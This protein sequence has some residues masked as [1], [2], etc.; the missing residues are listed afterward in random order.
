[1]CSSDLIFDALRLLKLAGTTVIMITHSLAVLKQA[2][3]A[4]LLCNGKLLDKGSIEKIQKYFEGKCLSCGHPNQPIPGE[5][6]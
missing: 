3:H 6:A 2:E 4:F 1:V 5:I